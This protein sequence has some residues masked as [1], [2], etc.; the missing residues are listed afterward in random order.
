MSLHLSVSHSALSDATKTN[1][2]SSPLDRSPP[3]ARKLV[4]DNLA[5]S[6]FNY[7]ARDGLR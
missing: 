6:H 7:A 3:G 4:A 2:S 1:A 5:K